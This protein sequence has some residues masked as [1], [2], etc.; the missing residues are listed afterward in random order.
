VLGI[1]SRAAWAVLEWSAAVLVRDHALWFGVSSSSRQ[2]QTVAVSSVWIGLAYGIRLLLVGVGVVLVALSLD[3]HL[4]PVYRW[5][6]VETPSGTQGEVV[7]DP[8]ERRG[9]IVGSEVANGPASRS[10]ART[11]GEYPT[12][13]V[14]ISLEI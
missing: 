11:E 1:T 8:P 4:P 7:V 10:V 14:V 9:G 3:P 2:A 12:R 6:D 5:S 13:S